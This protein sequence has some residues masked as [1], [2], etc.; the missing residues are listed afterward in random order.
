MFVKIKNVYKSKNKNS[1]KCYWANNG[2]LNT[3]AVYH[4]IER[5]SETEPGVE[6]TDT[7]CAAVM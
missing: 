3:N 4:H 6:V 1:L 7:V 5:Q 2:K